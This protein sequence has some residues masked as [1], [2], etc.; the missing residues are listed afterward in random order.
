MSQAIV[1]HEHG[2]SEV[3]RLEEHD[4]GEPGPGSVRVRVSASGVNFIDVYMRTGLYPRPTPFVVGLE[5]AGVVE[6]TGP[7]AEGFAEGDRVAWSSVPGSYAEV[8]IAPA[9]RLVPVPEGDLGRGGGRR[10]APGHDGALP[11]PRRS[12]DSAR[13]QRAGP[14][15]GGWGRAPADPDAQ[16][17]GCQGDGNL[18]DGGEGGPGQAGRCRRG[19]A[20]HREGLRLG[21]ARV[22]G[23]PGG[24]RGLRLGG[25]NHLRGQHE[26]AAPPGPDVSLRPVERRGAALRPEPAS[27]PWARCSSPDRAWPTTPRA[28]P[29]WRSAPARCSAPSPAETFE[30]RI[31][32]RFPLE[33]AGAAHDALEGRRTTGKVLLLPRG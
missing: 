4:P 24:R 22:D 23:W 18:L 19:G 16:G 30:V 2:G 5:G 6:A 20:L 8:L 13:R 29:S 33:Q 25:K 14:R 32:A 3:L 15:R 28:A 26:V 9:E 12:E 27:T 21:R 1:V 7:D 11:G 31:G 17:R 10:H